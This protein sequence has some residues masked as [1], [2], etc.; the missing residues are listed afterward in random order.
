MKSPIASINRAVSL[1]RRG[2]FISAATDVV[3]M[4]ELA[5]VNSGNDLTLNHDWLASRALLAE[6]NDQ[7]GQYNSVAELFASSDTL[8]A[9]TRSLSA[10]KKKYANPKGAPRISDDERRL[11][12]AGC[13]YELQAAI[14]SLRKF[15]SH[16]DEALGMMT[17]CRRTLEAISKVQTK[18]HGVNTCRF[19]GVLSLFHYWQGRVQMARNERQSAGQHF[20]ASMRETENNLRFHYAGQLSSIPP[21]DERMV[22]ASYGLASAM[23][24]GVAQLSHVSGDLTRALALLRPASALLMGTADNYRRGYAQMLIGAAQR[25]LA[26]RNADGLLRAMSTLENSLALFAGSEKRQLRHG[27]HQARSYHQLALAYTYLAQ[28]PTIEGAAKETQLA[29]ASH[30]CK[31]GYKLLEGF[32]DAGFGDPELRYDLRLTLSRILRQQREYGKAK[33]AATAAL[34]I[35]EAYRYAPGTSKAKSH[36]ALAEILL[37]QCSE[38]PGAAIDVL[39]AAERHLDEALRTAQSDVAMTAVIHLYG[40][41]ILVRRKQMFKAQQR[42]QEAWHKRER[43]VQN[44]WVRQL[45]AEVEKEVAQHGTEFTLNLEELEKELR[46]QAEDERHRPL[47]DVALEKFENFMVD[48]AEKAAPHESYTR[49]GLKKRSGSTSRR[50]SR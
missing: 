7:V 45:A 30:Y 27:L 31:L 11:I 10:A 40:A 39:N 4:G 9:I 6:I 1:V 23:G 19:H 8:R 32:E 20:D 5:D 21:S 16:L 3:L 50:G 24:F 22:Y 37:A 18:M 41:R 34:R 28:S 2:D 46:A 25:A 15:G 14:H 26:G 35:A 49:V 36:V 13:M 17:E 44:G 38:Q 48:W 29:E 42:F 33:G 12:R 43:E 47:W